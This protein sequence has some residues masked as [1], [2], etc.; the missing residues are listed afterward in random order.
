[1]AMPRRVDGAARSGGAGP[2]T[3]GALPETIRRIGAPQHMARTRIKICGITR[4]ADAIAAAEAGADAIGF[5]FHRPSPRWIEP[6]EAGK[7]VAAL[8]PFVTTVGLFV[9][10]DP[11]VVRA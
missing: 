8:P 4:L 9:D 7:I 3:F 5:V 6:R 10:V 2:L 1:M 11:D